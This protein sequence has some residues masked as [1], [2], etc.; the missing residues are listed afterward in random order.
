MYMS[1]AC[2]CPAQLGMTD[3]LFYVVNGALLV[4][5]FLLVR[6]MF[7]P[8]S[9]SFYAGQYH[10][11]DMVQA[12]G[13]MRWICHL[14][15]FIQF[16]FQLYWFVQLLRLARQVVRGLFLVA[17]S[18]EQVYGIRTVTSSPQDLHFKHK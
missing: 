10:Q 3:N 18:K 14:A 8:L 11:W 1:R 15:N 4:I 9:I 2:T 17:E 16:A 12:L 13:A 6:V 5:T 7:V